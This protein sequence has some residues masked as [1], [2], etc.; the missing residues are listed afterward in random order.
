MIYFALHYQPVLTPLLCHDEFGLSLQL[1][2]FCH[3]GVIQQVFGIEVTGRAAL[4][5][6][7]R[8]HVLEFRV[9]LLGKLENGFRQQLTF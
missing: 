8:A 6:L 2:E 7:K 4:S 5:N 3:F 1:R 9:G